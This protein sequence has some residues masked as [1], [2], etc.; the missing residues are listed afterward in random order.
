MVAGITDAATADAGATVTGQIAL[1]NKFFDTSDT[2]LDF[3]NQTNQAMAQA[4]G[5]QLNT[6]E[7]YQ[8][9]AAEVMA[10]EILVKSAGSVPNQPGV[11]P[12][13]G[14]EPDSTAQTMLGAYANSG[15]LTT[16]G[17]PY[18][19]PPWSSW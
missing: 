15:F 12:P 8:Q 10:R 4:A 19:R 13:A 7:T 1:Q 11:I 18:L 3:L 2:T 17:Q 9:Q 5:I 16:S 6:G 14:S